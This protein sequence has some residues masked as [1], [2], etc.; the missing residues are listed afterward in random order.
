M[1]TADILVCDDPQPTP[2]LKHFR[3][4]NPTA[5]LVWRNHIDTDGQLM[6][7]PRTPQGE[8]ASYILDECGVRDADAVITH[9]VE[10]FVHPEMSDRTFF[11][12]A[13]TEPHDD[14]NRPLNERE[15]EDGLAFIN[16]EIA[17]QNAQFAAEG[18]EDDIQPLLDP[19]KRRITLVAR[20]DE[21]KGMH[22]AMEL[23]ARIRR[24]MRA[25]GTTEEDLPEIV[26]V[27]NG[28]V[29]DP[30]GKPMYEKMLKLRREKYARE[31]EGIT[32]MRLR[33]N[34]AAMNALMHQS[35]IALQTSE[36]EGCE[37]RISDWIEHDVP[38]F[39][40]NIGGMPGQVV[41]G[42]SGGILDYDQPDHDLGRGSEAI[43]NLLLDRDK[44]AALRSTTHQQARLYNRREYTT[45]ANVTRFMRV[46]GY[47]LN[48]PPG[49]VAAD[50]VWKMSDFAQAA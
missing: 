40:F 47:V 30:S 1:Q 46:F 3:Q 43:T 38:A 9:P 21:S 31:Q 32:L 33:H 36:A 14:L 23:G 13:T 5:K 20:F 49:S 34:Y 8:V 10:A 41:D 18:R 50:R 35:D 11:A 7:D 39:V 12:P 37:T 2:Y 42:K 25:H 27:G 26:I 24:N 29:D 44:Y 48:I 19:N 28:S 6:A 15:I 17:K 22:H 45:T 16:V 4:V